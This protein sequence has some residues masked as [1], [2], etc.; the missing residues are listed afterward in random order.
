MLAALTK[1]P[2]HQPSARTAVSRCSPLRRHAPVPAACI[3]PLPDARLHQCGRVVFFHPAGN[4]SHRVSV[5]SR[6]QNTPPDAPHA[7]LRMPK[8]MCQRLPTLCNNRGLLAL[9]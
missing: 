2:Q 8:N 6:C 5:H 4:T 9:T 3:K 1:Q 7:R